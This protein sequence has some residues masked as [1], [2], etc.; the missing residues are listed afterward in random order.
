MTESKLY[1]KHIQP[2]LKRKN[3]FFERIELSEHPDIYTCNRQGK[4]LWIELKVINKSCKIIKPDWRKGQLSWI[5]RHQNF[6]GNS[7]LLC[8]WY[9]NKFYF[10]PPQEQ[11]TEEELQNLNKEI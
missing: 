7:I 9:I 10:L 5:K 11:Y 3:F 2:L 6:G 1:Q 4:V 8:L